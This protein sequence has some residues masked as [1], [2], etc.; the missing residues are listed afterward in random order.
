MTAFKKGDI[1]FVNSLRRDGTVAE[2]LKDGKYKVSVGP[3]SVTCQRA[4]LSE[5]PKTRKAKKSQKVAPLHHPALRPVTDSRALETIDLHGFTVAAALAEVEMRIDRAIIAD[6]ERLQ[7]VH[8]IGS[9]RLLEA[10]HKYLSN[11][12]VVS[13]YKLDQVNPGVTWVY[14]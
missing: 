2:L 9:G 6:L 7:I 14:F 5:P 10:I 11:L 8:G 3:V 13:S 4:E 1:V 12:S